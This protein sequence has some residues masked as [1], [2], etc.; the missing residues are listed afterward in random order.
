MGCSMSSHVRG[1]KAK[2][3]SVRLSLPAEHP[4]DPPKPR[5]LVFY[6]D[7]AEDQ[8]RSNEL[9]VNNYQYVKRMGHGGTSHVV[10]VRKGRENYAM[11]ICR[12]SEHPPSFIEQSTRN[13]T[14][15]AAILLRLSNPYVVKIYE[16]IE[17]ADDQVYIIM[18][19]C[20]GGDV[21]HCK[22]EELQPLFA[23]MLS[24]I[25]YLHTQR[26]AHRDIKPGNIMRHADGNIRLVDFGN[27]ILVPAS[28]KSISNGFTG[29]PSYF[30][31]EIYSDS[32]YN[33]FAADVWALGV[34]LYQM[35]FGRLP[36]S[37]T[38]LDDLA[39]NIRCETP[40]FP[41]NANPELVDL[42]QSMLKKSPMDRITVKQIW[43]HPWIRSYKRLISTRRSRAI[44][45]RLSMR[46]RQ[47]SIRRI[48]TFNMTLPRPP[49]RT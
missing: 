5:K 34:T 46:E 11:K 38:S 31:P 20:E 3:K 22:P 1:K 7:V 27:A 17:N 44:Y 40:S 26:I 13:P 48:S 23:Q 35:A 39:R 25:D 37:G 30:A 36:F 29:T 10:Q 4:N 15:E 43:K 9:K 42:I 32:S 49:R 19:L 12:I 21:T 45:K 24:A 2:K 41:E 8:F 18:E 28:R 16:L 33:P 6:G 47:E 14:D